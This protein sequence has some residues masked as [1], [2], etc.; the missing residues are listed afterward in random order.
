MLSGNIL[1]EGNALIFKLYM[2]YFD[3]QGHTG[4]SFQKYMHQCIPKSELVFIWTIFK[5]DLTAESL[6][7][8]GTGPAELQKSLPV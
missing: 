3:A 7:L 8:P 6:P 2:C 1:G 4:D 5:L